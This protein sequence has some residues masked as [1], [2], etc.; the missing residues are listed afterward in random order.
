M[1]AT[2]LPLALELTKP[3][4]VASDLDT[5]IRASLGVGQYDPK[6]QMS[7]T[8]GGG[9]GGGTRSSQQCKSYSGFLVIDL[10]L[11]LQVDDNDIL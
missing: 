7:Q 4:T 2:A 9:C 11:D 6:A 5:E 8:Y 10:T 3:V 1:S